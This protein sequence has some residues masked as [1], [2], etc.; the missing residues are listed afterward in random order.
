MVSVIENL[1]YQSYTYREDQKIKIRFFKKKLISARLSYCKAER[2]D[3]CE[4]IRN[5]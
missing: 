3:R 2:E 4:K 1:L 5:V